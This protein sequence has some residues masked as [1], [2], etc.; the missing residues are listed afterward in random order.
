MIKK[1]PAL[2]RIP[3]VLYSGCLQENFG[4]R[5]YETEVEYFLPKTL[6]IRPILTAIGELLESKPDGHPNI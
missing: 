1:D 6:N 4:L 2:S 5:A 3:V